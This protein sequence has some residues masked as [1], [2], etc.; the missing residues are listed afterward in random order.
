MYICSTIHSSMAASTCSNS[1]GHL[2]FAACHSTPCQPITH[3]CIFHA[4]QARKKQDRGGK[5]ET[6]T[7]E[8]ELS[9]QLSHKT[10]SKSRAYR[11][12]PIMAR[13]DLAA[14]TPLSTPSSG[15]MDR[16]K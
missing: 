7:A 3:S 12:P 9:P 16:M 11:S 15:G 10:P 5:K 6:L 13:E 1:D 14:L 2:T 4:Y 8:R